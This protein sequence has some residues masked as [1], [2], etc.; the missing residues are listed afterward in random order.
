MP[1]EEIDV[2]VP[3]TRL[4]Y[5]K[6]LYFGMLVAAICVGGN[7]ALGSLLSIMAIGQ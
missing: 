2:W 7:T 6:L 1:K 5:F 4:G 3:E